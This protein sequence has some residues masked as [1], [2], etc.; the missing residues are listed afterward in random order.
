MERDAQMAPCTPCLRGV[1]LGVYLTA[2]LRL[3]LGSQD[4]EE[5]LQ[6]LDHMG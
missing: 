2:N 4:C 3:E 1:V 6:T 5:T